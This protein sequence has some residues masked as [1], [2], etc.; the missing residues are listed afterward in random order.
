MKLSTRALSIEGSKTAR[1]LPLLQ[2]MRSEGKKVINLAVGE[3]EYPTSSGVIVATQRALSH[4]ETRYSDVPGLL[5]LRKAL[6]R[7][8]DGM[9]FENVIISNGAKQCL[10]T[11][12][13]VIC[14][15]LDEVILPVPCW[16]SFTEQIR[17]TG[18][19][20]IFVPM[21]GSC[22]DLD[23]IASAITPKTKAILV[24]SPHNPTGAVYSMEELDHIAGL[25]HRH[26][27][28][29]IADE[30]YQSFIYDGITFPSLFDQK[31]IRSR[32]ITVRSFSKQYNMTGFR[33]GYAVANKKITTAMIRLQ[34]HLC[35]NVCT[36]VQYGAIAA[37][38]M[39]RTEQDHQLTD[40]TH[41][42]NLAYE[43]ISRHF[44]CDKP[45]GAFYL[46]P[47]LGTHLAKGQSDQDFAA[48]LLKQTG[49]AVVP[50]EA[51]FF[52]GY[53]RICY[54]VP[55][56]QLVLALKKIEEVL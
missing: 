37:T 46:F 18:A 11:I 15:P 10:Y 27:L 1:F 4:Q 56:N 32:L 14:D 52:P 40:L 31:K 43:A 12:F 25:A 24:N 35:G 16:V 44:K 17:L 29:V 8:F 21:Q 51:F 26:D 13:Q 7:R 33:I 2:Q 38:A 5:E 45:K 22:L 28:F 30:A 34:S 41:K 50:G 54:A 53:I 36:F 47:Y 49:V 23:A 55:E 9:T 3:P 48:H 6:A 20:P 19:V 42:R 39:N